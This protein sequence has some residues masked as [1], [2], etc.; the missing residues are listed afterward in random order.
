MIKSTISLLLMCL[1]LM[2]SVAFSQ[3]I[4]DIVICIDASGSMRFPFPTVTPPSYTCSGLPSVTLANSR[5]EVFHSS[6]DPSLSALVSKVIGPLPALSDGHLAVV[7]FPIRPSMSGTTPCGSWPSISEQLPPSTIYDVSTS[8][9]PNPFAEIIDLLDESHDTDVTQNMHI[10]CN[11]NGTPIGDAL[12]LSKSILGGISGA[13]GAGDE[14]AI[15]LITDGENNRDPYL[16]FSMTGSGLSV[17]STTSDPCL[18]WVHDGTSAIRIDAIGI[19]DETGS[20]YEELFALT[21]AGVGNGHFYAFIG[22]SSTPLPAGATSSNASAIWWDTA[23]TPLGGAA[24]ADLKQ[25]LDKLFQGYLHYAPIIDPNGILPAYESIVDS[26]FVT[27]LDKSLCFPFHWF[28]YRGLFHPSIRIILEDGTIIS[29]DSSKQDNAYKIVRGNDYVYFFAE[30]PFVQKHYGKWR[31]QIDGSM[32]PIATPY[33]YSIFTQSDLKIT[34]NFDRLGFKTGD[35]FSGLFQIVK[36]ESKISGV[37]GKASISAPTEWVGNWNS[38]NKLNPQ[39][40]EKVKRDDWADDM[41][42]LSRKRIVLERERGLAFAQGIRTV[43]NLPLSTSGRTHNFRFDEEISKPGLYE[44]TFEF[45]GMDSLGR[46]FKRQI[47]FHKYVSINVDTTWKHSQIQFDKVS[48]DGNFVTADVKVT[49]QDRFGNV[50]LPDLGSKI[51]INVVAA[52]GDTLSGEL[53]DDVDGSY[54]KRVSYDKSKG[55]PTV[56]VKFRDLAF[57][58]RKLVPTENDG[59]AGVRLTT[60]AGYFYFD[61]DLPV[62]DNVVY[63]VRASKA[64][65]ATLTLAAELGISPTQDTSPSSE[66]GT[67]AH[68]NLNAYYHL[69]KKGL[70]NFL[71]FGA[72]VMRF[73]GF[74]T[75]ATGAAINFGYGIKFG[76]LRGLDLRLEARDFV[77]FNL[78]GQKVSHNLQTVMGLTWKIK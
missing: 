69:N 3:D 12:N 41:A 63:G 35:K 26:L 31:F 22:I 65:N 33:S 23:A 20:K 76:L 17:S 53:V 4:G 1:W 21:Q 46:P 57:A 73:Q 66:T 77:A 28:P 39:E 70:R 36:N 30:E 48:Q 37:V 67:V 51:A 25:A 34:T 38:M 47:F 60:F 16:G 74:T 10:D 43:P 42:L 58:E 49:F 78:Y 50:A 18:S 11:P 9:V 56:F 14:Q 44:L 7:R 27:S 19:G 61:N 29:T 8:V 59:D 15:L 64:I 40:L 13:G 71:T 72:G 6:I 55:D 68:A 32:L 5:Y 62:K 75:E 2:A 52:D 45:T 24:P 54:I